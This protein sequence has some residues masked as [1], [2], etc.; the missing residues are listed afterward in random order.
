MDR[1]APRQR[2][3]FGRRGSLSSLVWTDGSGRS[4]THPW[5][6]LLS[7]ERGDWPGDLMWRRAGGDCIPGFP[8]RC[9]VS[10]RRAGV[11]QAGAPAASAPVRARTN[12]LDAGKRRPTIGSEEK[13]TC[14]CGLPGGARVVGVVS[15]PP[16]RRPLFSVPTVTRPLV[17]PACPGRQL[18]ARAKAASG[19]SPGSHST[20]WPVGSLVRWARM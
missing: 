5:G 4:A 20:C 14:G 12:E 16:I 18:V 3:Q 7:R 10:C 13:P 2:P 8:R 6:S 19:G 17:S 11:G 15:H 1:Y 9:R